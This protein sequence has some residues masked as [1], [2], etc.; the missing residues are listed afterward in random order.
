MSEWFQDVKDL[1]RVKGLSEQFLDGDVLRFRQKHLEEELKEFDEAILNNDAEGAVDALIDMEVLILGTLYLGRVNGDLA[2]DE[3]FKA[4]LTKER[5]TKETRPGSRGFDLI[6]PVGWIAPNHKGNTGLF[7]AAIQGIL[8][9]MD[10]TGIDRKEKFPVPSHIIT[11]QAYIA[12]ALDKTHDYDDSE[13]PDFHHFKYYPEGINNIMYEIEKK[14][15]RIKH[16][17]KRFFRDGTLP[18]TDS[19]H[20]SFRDI[21]IYSGIGDTI[22]GGKLEGQT[23]NRDIFNREIT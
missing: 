16:G 10:K 19:L 11:L 18:K 7:D 14:V 21:S 1:Y 8:A 4:N 17:L 12:H 20:D 23:E 15:K 9:R 22:L 6:K 3:V 2:W 13:D 5:G